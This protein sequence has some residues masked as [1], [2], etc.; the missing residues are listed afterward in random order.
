MAGIDQAQ[1]NFNPDALL[2]LNV[3]L[4]LI[5]FGVGLDLHWQDVKKLRGRWLVLLVGLFGQ[6]LLLPVLTVGLA[7]FLKPT[8][9][10][11]LGMII[12]AACPGGSVSNFFSHLARGDVALSIALSAVTSAI[13]FVT[14]PFSI[15]F[16]G[17]FVPDVAQLL[18]EV[19]ID[20]LEMLVL[21]AGVLLLPA[22]IGGLVGTFLPALAKKLRTPFKV[23]SMGAFGL[24]VAAAFVANGR[25]FLAQAHEIVGLVAIHNGLALL[26]GIGLAKVCRLHETEARSIAIEVGIQNTALGLTVIFTFFGGLGGT[27]LV[28]AWW[29]VWHLLTGAGIA[30]WWR[31]RRLPQPELMSTMQSD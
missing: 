16:W 12:I 1:L 19:R 8:A 14:T 20:W 25:L 7:L 3:L 21:V 27:A 5:M 23:F 17:Q 11:A 10:L 15:A 24:F 26:A 18:R 4:A 28:T 2:A 6:W 29:G 13:C 30:L 22:S 9:S 31:R